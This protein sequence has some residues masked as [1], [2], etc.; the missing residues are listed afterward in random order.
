MRPAMPC[1][2]VFRLSE[3]ELPDPCIDW[4]LRRAQ[5]R[6]KAITPDKFDTPIVRP[7]PAV[8][9]QSPSAPLPPLEVVLRVVGWSRSDLD[10]CEHFAITANCAFCPRLIT[11]FDKDVVFGLRESSGVRELQPSTAGAD[12]IALVEAPHTIHAAHKDCLDKARANGSVNP[13]F[14]AP[15][16]AILG[17]PRRF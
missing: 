11:D 15:L 16:S 17:E 14:I 13:V 10:L 7:A 3:D 4:N 6:A 9:G 2:D 5:A 12:G 8:K 1:E